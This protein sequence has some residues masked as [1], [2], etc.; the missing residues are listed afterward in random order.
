MLA[1][2]PAILTGFGICSLLFVYVVFEEYIGK[3][4]GQGILGCLTIGMINYFVPSSIALVWNVWNI[5]IACL[6]GIPGVLVLYLLRI[7]MN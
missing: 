7:I 1:I 2:H 3:W 4:I 6:F 5:L